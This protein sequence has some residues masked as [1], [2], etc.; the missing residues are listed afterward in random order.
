MERHLQYVA[1]K[2]DLRRDIEFKAR[3]QSVVFARCNETDAGFIYKL[4]ECDGSTV[5]KA[6]R[7]RLYQTLYGRDG[8]ALWLANYMDVFKNRE[9][10]QE[11]GNFLAAKIPERVRDP[12]TAE[13]LIPKD[14]LFEFR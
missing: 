6:E 8:F 9:M 14:P 12:K 4:D 7:L 5:D 11:V 10:A 1:D 3:V 13:K 2:F